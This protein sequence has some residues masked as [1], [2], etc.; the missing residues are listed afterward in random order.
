MPWKSVLVWETT[1]NRPKSLHWYDRPKLLRAITGVGCE[2]TGR[3]RS[4]QVYRAVGEQ[5]AGTMPVFLI[6]PRTKTEFDE[7]R[8]PRR[9][10]PGSWK[11]VVIH[12]PAQYF[13]PTPEEAK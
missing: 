6:A 2:G 1:P 12:W 10:P 7:L 3:L 13:E 5:R 11:E 4:G 8:N 9:T